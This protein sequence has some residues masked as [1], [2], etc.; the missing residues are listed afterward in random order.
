MT[1]LL[2]DMLDMLDM[3]NTLQQNCISLFYD[4]TWM[5]SNLK[6]K[7]CRCIIIVIITITESADKNFVG[8]S[9]AIKMHLLYSIVQL[10]L[11]SFS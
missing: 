6:K 4:V 11:S 5:F 10:E 3:L 1:N 2:E 8:D 9:N 7:N